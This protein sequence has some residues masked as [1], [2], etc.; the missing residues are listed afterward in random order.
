M[1]FFDE[2][3]EPQSSP[4]AEPRRPRPAGRGRPPG[5]PPGGN[6]QV[7]NR[8]IA[9]VIAVVVIIVV[10]AV[11]IH[12]CESS[13]AQS[14]L[15]DYST[16]VYNLIGRS[17][18]I[19]KK[20]FGELHGASLKN[21][22]GAVVTALDTSLS[23]ATS[24]LQ[25]ANALNAP[26]EMTAA[27]RNLVLVMTMRKDGI[28][29]IAANLQTALSKATAQDGVNQIAVASSNLYASDVLYKEYVG[30]EI[31]RAL[32]S[33]GVT[34]GGS[35]SVQIN[36]GQFVPDLGWLIR[37]N[38]ATWVGAQLPTNVANQGRAGVH[39]HSLNQVLVGS[40]ALSPTALNQVPSSPAP[41]FQL[42]I[43][44]GGTVKEYDVVCQVT[45]EG[46]S[47]TGTATLPVTNPGQ[48]TNCPVTLP[49]SPTAG[50][51]KVI[52]EVKPVPYEKN[53]KNNKLTFTIQFG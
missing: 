53:N 5:R 10:M 40:T 11:V 16:S 22:N 15:K 19:G 6:Q 32:N 26:S 41:T 44:N 30:P 13:Q 8:R 39:G 29:L 46:L 9:A 4:R 45:V 42:N 47:D 12:G 14:S 52:A 36:S 50:T 7:Q 43:T 23:A 2:A 28:R 49:A 31:A 20:V 33:S 35:S 24:Q 17:N 48:T 25:Q 51:Y 21:Q 38:I 3:D 37:T 1:S 27:Q 34:V 18:A